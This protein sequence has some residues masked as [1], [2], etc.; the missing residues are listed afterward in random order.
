MGPNRQV[1]IGDVSNLIS[2]SDYPTRSS[3]WFF[4]VPNGIL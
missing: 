3:F 4:V 2:G 1:D